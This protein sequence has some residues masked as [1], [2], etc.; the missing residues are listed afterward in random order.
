MTSI[1]VKVVL[2][3]LSCLSV[4]PFAFSLSNV[5][6][7]LLLETER[8]RT[9]Q[10][11]GQSTTTNTGD[12][13]PTPSR[14]P[15]STSRN[16]NLLYD[17]QVV[18]TLQGH[19]LVVRSFNNKLY[20][21]EEVGAGRFLLRGANLLT[22]PDVQSDFVRLRG[23]LSGGNTNLDGLYE[24]EG[25]GVPAGYVR[26]NFPDGAT[27]YE[28]IHPLTQQQTPPGQPS[29]PTQKPVAPPPS[30]PPTLPAGKPGSR[31]GVQ[32]LNA[33]RPEPAGQFHPEQFGEKI[34]SDNFKFSV[35]FAGERGIA[36]RRA[37]GENLFQLSSLNEA[38]K[39]ELA[40]GDGFLYMTESGIHGELEGAGYFESSL[41]EYYTYIYNRIPALGGNGP[42]NSVGIGAFD[43]ETSNYWSKSS[44]TGTRFFPAWESRKKKRIICEFDGKTRSLE[45]LDA[46]GLMEREQ[47]VR[48]GNRVALLF[49]L[50]RERARPGVKLS[51][52]P[53]MYQGQ[54]NL[55]ALTNMTPF[56]ES[57]PDVRYIGGKPDGTIT[58]R[59]PN[60]GTATYVLK[61]SQYENEDI[62]M[63]YY[64]LFHF[65]ISGADFREIWMKNPT[66]KTYSDLWTAIKPWDIVADEKGF[67][68]MN[69]DFMVRK[70]GKPHPIIRMWEP[71][72]EDNTAGVVD[73]VF[74]NTTAARVP[75][76][77]LK[78]ERIAK[79]NGDV[80][81][82]WQA[83]YLAYSRYMVT[84]FFAGDEPGW[85]VH[86][87]PSG[88]S[89]RLSGV[90]SY[91]HFLHPY[92]SVYQ[93]RADM[94]P[95]ESW[96]AGSTLIED[97]EV[98]MNGSTQWVA[99]TGAQAHGYHSGKMDPPK[100]AAM[101]RWK[102]NETGGHTV[103]ILIGIKQGFGES[104][105]H[106]IRVPN[107]GLNGTVFKTT[108]YGPS[109]H[110]FRFDIPA[111]ERGQIYMAS[112]V[113]P[114]A[115]YAGLVQK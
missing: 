39:Q 75:F 7:S 34:Y 94:Q 32:L 16:P 1:H 12:T 111:S 102:A 6:A 5:R 100:P 10:L 93:A 87:F 3:F 46:Q 57:F 76:P 110:L 29:L 13:L 69:R 15:A 58:L 61:G 112:S 97:P 14:N 80:P 18:G 31:S 27:Y 53:S 91:Q 50:V 108:I 45:E 60:G 65:D 20:L 86:I 92:T 115:G 40:F 83:P 95:L 71:V 55:D 114:P 37:V 109:A 56:L 4:T 64:Y 105:T 68:Q 90:D 49:A 81:K 59:R 77:H 73:G 9:V 22:R 84:R 35:D 62:M 89:V 24:P 48:R 63:G 99:Y 88:S 54:P 41:Q 106:L 82:V 66:K 113:N 79:E 8:D 2:F 67:L 47:N 33:Y 30:A 103:Y 43:I 85:G 78:T 19:P 36:A 96:F 23:Q 42:D 107:G 11:S 21:T 51:Y 70:Y 74:G 38:Q 104:S 101:L 26:K 17:K 25:V 28:P 52:G 72:Y 98:K 44:Y